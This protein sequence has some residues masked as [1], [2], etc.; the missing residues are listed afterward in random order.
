MAETETIAA[1]TP[2]LQ[3]E[4][5]H[6]LAERGKE[7]SPLLIMTHNHPDPD[8]LASA[9]ALAFLV[10]KLH[11][12]KARVV[13]GGIVGRVEN[14]ALVRMLRLPVHPLREGE[15]KRYEHIAL[16][17]TQPPFQN[18]P[19]PKNRKAT[20][21]VDHHPRNKRTEAELALI[22]TSYGAT[23]TLMTEALL[24][25]GLPAPK[26]LSTALLYGISS[27]TQNLGR[28]ASPRDVS[29]YLSLLKMANLH[30][31]S[32]IQNPPRPRSFFS[33]LARG[34]QRAFVY[35]KI[36]GVHLGELPTPDLVAQMADFLLSHEGMMWSICTGRYHGHLHISL[37]SR[38]PR[39]EAGRLLKKLLGGGNR[40][41]GHGMIA[42]GNL[43]I[44]EAPEEKWREQ[45][46]TLTSEF[47]KSLK[48]DPKPELEFP[49]YL[50]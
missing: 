17:D 36:I 2:G 22:D 14:Q 10:E 42:G 31:L 39:A 49:F 15:V 16:V 11:G 21:V 50:S 47:F 46:D 38:N 29:A 6:F 45:E 30:A 43:P 18:N 3:H 40:G 37:R 44:G 23:S 34:I 19:F 27:E 24:A 48:L 4:L 25:S 20:L 13:Y 5:L 35:K 33:T 32:R 12:V 28:E 1:P 9:V 7:I 26:N 8:C 41:G